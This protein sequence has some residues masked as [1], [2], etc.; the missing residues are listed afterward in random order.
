MIYSILFVILASISYWL[1]TR[2]IVPAE[3]KLNADMIV[4]NGAADDLRKG[5]HSRRSLS[6]IHI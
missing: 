2:K 6:L 1:Y 4:S 5:F 3:V